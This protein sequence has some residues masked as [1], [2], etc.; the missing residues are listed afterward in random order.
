MSPHPGSETPPEPP[1]SSPKSPA[2]GPGFTKS[3]QPGPENSGPDAPPQTSSGDVD[4]GDIDPEDIDPEATEPFPPGLF[5]VPVPDRVFGEIPTLPDAALKALLALIGRSFRFDPEASSWTNPRDWFA[6]RPLEE[7]SG[8]SDE[9]TRSGLAE[10]EERGWAEVDR[11]AQGYR[12]RLATDV[13]EARYTYVPSALLTSVGA[14]PSGA[15]LRVLMATLR[16]TWGWTQAPPHGGTRSGESGA[17]SASTPAGEGQAKGL[18]SE[19]AAGPVHQR[20]AEISVPALAAATG[21]SAP[22]VRQA[23]RAL[24]KEGWIHRVRF[25]QSAYHYRV[26]TEPL[27]PGQSPEDRGSKVGEK[28]E[29][30]SES[31]SGP[32]AKRPPR[33]TSF[34]K[35]PGANE[36]TAGRQQTCP[37]S[38][39]K[40]VSFREQTQAPDEKPTGAEAAGE[41]RQAPEGSPHAV[42]ESPKNSSGPP[43]TE[44]PNREGKT[45][46]SSS[47]RKPRIPKDQ[48]GL[49]Q[50][51]LA[52]GIWPDR[53]RE[54]L[55]RYSTRRMEANFELWRRRKNDPEA[56]PIGDDGA[57]L[58]AAITDGYADLRET[59][60]SET[61]SS[62]A[63]NQASKESPTQ[64]S[65]GKTRVGHVPGPSTGGPPEHKQK[66]SPEEKKRLVRRHDGVEAGHFHRFRHG[67]SPTE[68]QFLY[69]DPEEGG[70]ARKRRVA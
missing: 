47:S 56:P 51:L 62:R 44:R 20:W 10:L 55:K 50:K 7:A 63:P 16:R 13:P 46:P 40:R 8:L 21:R 32:T 24:A 57:W 39:Y 52:A 36:L 58:C 49:Y 27:L 65:A 25:G 12:Y 9:G 54:C 26:R 6:R 11:S 31:E 48:R 34:S 69:L 64:N 18:A 38:S 5:R 3:K 29:E 61:R 66:V 53:A 1:T 67:K 28:R 37:P 59:R 17:Q 60:T 41:A 35:P 30:K 14:L 19:D 70:P 23:A 42:P 68:E 33:G 43:T 22:S 2:E 4:P 15:A 45:N